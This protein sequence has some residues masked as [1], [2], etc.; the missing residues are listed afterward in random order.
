MS[1][2]ETPDWLIEAQNKSWEPEILISGLTLTSLFILSGHLYNFFGLLIQEYA[3][4]EVIAHISYGISLII[5]T[6]LKMILII[7]L[8]LRGLW[9][10]LVGLSYVYPDGVNRANLPES[11]N[12]LTLPRPDE[13]VITIERICSLLFSFIFSSVLF[14]LGF[15]ILY[16]IF[17]LVYLFKFD[18]AVNRILIFLILI[19]FIVIN[20][21]FQYNL[22]KKK[23]TS[24]VAS[25]GILTTILM[26]YLTN[27]GQK[28]TSA[29]FL[30]FFGLL[31]LLTFHEVKNFG[32][33]NYNSAE[34]PVLYDM[35]YSARDWYENS[36]DSQRRI[37]KASIESF[38][39]QD[40]EITLF[41][42]F[43]QIDV[44]LLNWLKNHPEERK[45][46][47]LANNKIRFPGLFSVSVADSVVTGLQWFFSEHPVT[48][49]SGLETVI[50]T[51]W[52]QSGYHE[53]RLDKYR[54]WR[55]KDELILVENWALIPF[56]K[57]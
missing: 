4:I 3:V 7:H 42:A 37:E 19:L 29:M 32:F 40:N 20:L 5:L 8:I 55:N 57:Q 38:R 15:I 12:K 2:K 33:R 34:N 49:Q 16:I 41:I 50:P 51:G 45:K 23:K 54:L 14:F 10:A 24:G 13:L 25:I 9:T 11:E 36:R 22:Q 53:V 46:L 47:T 26:I 17:F 28:K 52:V 39:Q 27:L 31:V 43:Y 1:T 6:G 48:G 21:I 30:I 35:Q 44:S 18:Y 56:I